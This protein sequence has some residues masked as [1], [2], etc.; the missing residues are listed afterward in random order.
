M[1][2][3]TRFLSTGGLARRLGVSLTTVRRLEAAGLVTSDRLEGSD[4]RVFAIG[5]VEPIRAAMVARRGG[6]K[7]GAVPTAA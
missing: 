1:E 4:R 6:A 7:K 3:P 5:D 2:T